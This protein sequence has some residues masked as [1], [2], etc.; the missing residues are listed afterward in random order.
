MFDYI[1][2]LTYIN[3]NKNIKERHTEPSCT[4]NQDILE[5]SDLTIP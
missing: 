5:A 2:T 1:R 3:Y 4:P